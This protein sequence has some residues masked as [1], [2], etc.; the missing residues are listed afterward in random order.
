MIGPNYENPHTYDTLNFSLIKIRDSKSCKISIKN[1]HIS[2]SPNLLTLS[3][4][5]T[6]AKSMT[7]ALDLIFNIKKRFL[8]LI[9][10]F[11]RRH[12]L[13]CPRSVFSILPSSNNSY[14][15][16]TNAAVV[17]RQIFAK[18]SSNASLSF[19]QLI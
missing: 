3:R 17:R 2:K 14:I 4:N 18:F 10:N 6:W 19:Q 11:A 7:S 1:F 5:S 8:I 15:N 9:F 16:I 13:F 12:R